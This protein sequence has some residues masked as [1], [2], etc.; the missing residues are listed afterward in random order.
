M[1]RITARCP[2]K[3]NLTFEIVGELPDGYH[4]VSTLMQCVDLEDELV[5][6]IE[7][8]DTFS[9]TIEPAHDTVYG[10]FPAGEMNLITRAFRAFLEATPRLS[11]VQ[12][13]ATVNK[14]IP[15]SAGLAGGSGNAACTLAALNYYYENALSRQE[16]LILAGKLG[17][18]V[19]FLLE[20][21][22][23]VGR[24]R[25]DDLTAVCCN[26]AF[27]FVMV[28]PGNIAI[29]TAWAYDLID[30]W[31][32]QAPQPGWTPPDLVGALKAIEASQLELAATLFGN[33]F[34]PAIF[35][36]FPPLAAIKGRLLEL[37]CWS[38]NLTGSGPTVYGIARD[39][40]SAR[41]IRDAIASDLALAAEL[42]CQL[43]CMVARS[44][45][46][47]ARLVS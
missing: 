11:P 33:D 23:A 24:G 8:S 13:T 12:V 31:D 9:M 34:E 26:S 16:L 39:A 47:G 7:P 5:F 20:G 43:D 10:D 36:Q 15:V 41:Q 27:H 44:V 37:G 3:V 28:K 4:E 17:A 6:Q 35:S 2:A 30:D 46:H 19:P 22:L 42:D 38:S 32:F 1:R 29:A 18:D 21:G 45:S 14:R 25:G 40:E